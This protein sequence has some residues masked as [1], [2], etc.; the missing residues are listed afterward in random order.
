[1]SL[2]DALELLYPQLHHV[3]VLLIHLY[4]C[5]MSLTSL[6]LCDYTKLILQNKHIA[7]LN[8]SDSPGHNALFLSLPGNFSVN[9]VIEGCGCSFSP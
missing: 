4:L 8:C 7:V 9:T 6:L 3:S 5:H 1:M 2:V